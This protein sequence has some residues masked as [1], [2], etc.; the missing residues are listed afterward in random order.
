MLCLL[1]GFLLFLPSF[2]PSWLIQLYFLSISSTFNGGMWWWIV[3]QNVH[4]YE[5]YLLFH[6][7]MTLCGRLGVKH[8]V[9]ISMAF[10]PAT[11]GYFGEKA[12]H[13]DWLSGSVQDE[14][15]FIKYIILVNDNIL[16]EMRVNPE[17]FM[18]STIWGFF[19]GVFWCHLQN[20]LI[21]FPTFRTGTKW[22]NKQTKILQSPLPSLEKKGTSIGQQWK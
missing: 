18:T 14:R 2:C 21:K 20:I 10:A 6:P 4:L 19:C 5:E 16:L 8:S 11:S 3:N 1:K 7:D 12:C 22:R 9:C 13:I 15:T 17:V